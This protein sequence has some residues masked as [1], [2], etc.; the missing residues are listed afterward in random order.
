MQQLFHLLCHLLLYLRAPRHGLPGIF[1]QKSLDGRACAGVHAHL[2][3]A[4]RNHGHVVEGRVHRLSGRV[5]RQPR[6]VQI[7]AGVRVDSGHARLH[8]LSNEIFKHGHDRIWFLSG[9]PPVS[10]LAAPL[11]PV[12]LLPLQEPSL[13]KYVLMPCAGCSRVFCLVCGFIY[14]RWHDPLRR[15]QLV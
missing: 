2:W 5:C 11:S 8:I 9:A 3:V 10:A 1:C 6:V 7:L 12:V 4:G 13:P 14:H 15:I